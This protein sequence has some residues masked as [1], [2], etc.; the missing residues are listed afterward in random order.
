M[1]RRLD[2]LLALVVFLCLILLL[3]SC[4][5]VPPKPQKGSSYTAKLQTLA[6]VDIPDAPQLVPVGQVPT[7][8]FVQGENQDTPSTQTYERTVNGTAITEKIST[9]MGTAQHDK[10]RDEWATVAQL[11]AKLKSY[12]SIKLLG[13]GLILA[14]L[15]MFHPT[16]RAFTGTTV[17][18]ATGATGAALIFG[19][20]L[21]AGNETL[22]LLLGLGGVAAVY[23][24]R[25][26]GYLQGM[27]DANK[28]GIPDVI[29]SLLQRQEQNKPKE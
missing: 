17:Q 28:N 21:M 27:V 25:R 1:S 24:F 14:A 29:E 8:N 11:E 2:N 9:S 18:V 15:A 10:A 7:L 12:G 16:V 23:M 3:C 20:Q 4:S 6:L 13:F 26:H 5:M 22:V 19:A